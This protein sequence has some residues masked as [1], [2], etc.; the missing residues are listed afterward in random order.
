M[1]NSQEELDKWNHKTSRKIGRIKEKV[2]QIEKLEIQNIFNVA[3]LLDSVN[4]KQQALFLLLGYLLG[5]AIVMGAFKAFSISQTL[6][7]Q[8]V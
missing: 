8:P 5:M 2:R 1:G 4:I 6:K 3:L 7:Q